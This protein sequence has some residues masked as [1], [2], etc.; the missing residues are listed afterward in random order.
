MII[1]SYKITCLQRCQFHNKEKPSPVAV[2]IIKYICIDI[3]VLFFLQN[4]YINSFAQ[5]F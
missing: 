5:I 2:T 3:C 1:V 4:V